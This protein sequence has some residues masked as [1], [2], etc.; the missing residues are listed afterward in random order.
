VS[1]GLRQEGLPDIY[2]GMLLAGRYEVQSPI[3][4]GA[5][6]TVHRALDHH[7]G[8]EVAVKRLTDFTQVTR[9][10]IEARLLSL[11]SH[12]RVVKVIDHFQEPSGY[13]IVMDLVRGF[14]LAEILRQRGTPGLSVELV[15]EYAQQACEALDYVHEQRIVHRDVKPENL[16]LGEQGVILVDFGVARQ[17]DAEDP[18]EVGTVGVGTPRYM[19][20]EIFAGGTVSERSDVFSL[21]ATVSTLLCGQLP[22]YGDRRALNERVPGVSAELSDAVRAGMEFLPEKRIATISAFA[23]AI[24]RP[25]RGRTGHSFV[26]A[27]DAEEEGQVSLIGALVRTAAGVLDSAAA[28]IALVDPNTSELVFHAAWGPGADDIVGV[29]L[30]PGRGISGSVATSGEPTFIS[31]CRAD[32]RFAAQ[33][34]ANTGHVPNTMLVVPLKHGGRVLG[35]LSLLDRRDGLPY[36]GA[37]VSRATLFAELAVVALAVGPEASP[38]A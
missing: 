17:L 22:S 28:S 4:R 38:S 11:L 26:R 37:D 15:L 16:I 18:D 23:K 12:P 10:E 33:I 25:L 29:R 3:S 21:A 14:D 8:D 9:F 32:P 30:E 20:P 7:V 35:V 19:A 2:A 13:F 36:G 5:I 24:G 6:G 34:A 1:E 31:E 27:P